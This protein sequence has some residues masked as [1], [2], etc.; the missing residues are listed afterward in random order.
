MSSRFLTTSDVAELMLPVELTP[1][2]RD[3]WTEFILPGGELTI[4]GELE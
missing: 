1:R 4:R 3:P 2:L